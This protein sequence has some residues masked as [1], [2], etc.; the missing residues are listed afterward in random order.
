MG[1]NKRVG[2]GCGAGKPTSGRGRGARKPTSERQQPTARGAAGPEGV[3]VRRAA[4]GGG[5]LIRGAKRWTAQSEA[6]FLDHLAATCNVT[7]SAAA[8]GF[9]KVTVYNHQ[10]SDPAFMERW[11]WALA[12]GYVRIEMRLVQT[13]GDALDGIPDPNSPFPPMTIKDAIAVLQLHRARVKD[14]GARHP[15]R[16]GRPRSLD[17]MRASIIAKLEAFDAARHA[18]RKGGADGDGA[19]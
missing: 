15:G 19:A 5:K 6:V 10:R 8:A 17:E 18:R 2:R 3:F 12:Q 11:E 9:S 16:R 4:R 13:T 1:G 7:A 14:D